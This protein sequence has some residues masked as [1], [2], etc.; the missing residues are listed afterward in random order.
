MSFRHVWLVLF[1]PTNEPVQFDGRLPKLDVKWMRCAQRG[2][3]IVR[4][5]VLEAWPMFESPREFLA[6]L[7]YRFDNLQNEYP[8]LAVVTSDDYICTGSWRVAV[9]GRLTEGADFL[10]RTI[11]YV[12]LGCLYRRPAKITDCGKT[13]TVEKM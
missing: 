10:D 12:K 13:A 2:D 8:V 5:Q 9:I 11:S 6:E 7:K 1:A 4:M 3:V